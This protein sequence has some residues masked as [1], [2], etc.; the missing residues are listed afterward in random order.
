[1][2]RYLGGNADALAAMRDGSRNVGAMYAY[3]NWKLVPRL[4]LGYGPATPSTTTSPTVDW[5]A[6]GRA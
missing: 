5:S 6:L 4:T 3:D 1:M 2:Q